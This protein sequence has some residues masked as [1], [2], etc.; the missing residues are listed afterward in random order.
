MHDEVKEF[1]EENIYIVEKGHLEMF[2]YTA[3]KRFKA[4]REYK[5]T[6]LI[7]TLNKIDIDTQAAQEYLFKQSFTEAFEKLKTSDKKYNQ[8]QLSQFL[9][10][11]MPTIYG[12]SIL[13]CGRIIEES[14]LADIRR[15]SATDWIL[16]W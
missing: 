11:M 10:A 5:M 3:G 15:T 13:D 2:L 6:Q 1:I 16:Q 12:L 8:M 14:K 7:D 9:L 4:Q